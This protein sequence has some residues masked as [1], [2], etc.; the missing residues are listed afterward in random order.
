MDLS[1]Y[2]QWIAEEILKSSLLMFLGDLDQVQKPSGNN[3]DD[4]DDDGHKE[5]EFLA[6]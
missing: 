4:N 5:S 6:P 3:Q 2:G 1:Y